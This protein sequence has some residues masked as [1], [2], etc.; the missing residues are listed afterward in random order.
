MIYISQAQYF[1]VGVKIASVFMATYMTGLSNVELVV[2][3]QIV[4]CSYATTTKDFNLEC[5]R[6]QL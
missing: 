6:T 1:I 3:F 5:K 4:L 2:G